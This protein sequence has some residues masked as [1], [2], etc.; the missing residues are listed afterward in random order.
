MQT[1]TSQNYLNKIHQ[2]EK[3]KNNNKYNQGVKKKNR[4]NYFYSNSLVTNMST[5]PS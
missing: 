2:Q 3:K 1:I 5:R 4:A